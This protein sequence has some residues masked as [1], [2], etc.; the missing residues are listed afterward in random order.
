MVSL[1]DTPYLESGKMSQS[2][3]LTIWI[4]QLI[5]MKSSSIVSNLQVR[6]NYLFLIP[7][8]LLSFTLIMIKYYINRKAVLFPILNDGPW[9]DLNR[10]H[11][12]TLSP[13]L[14]SELSAIDN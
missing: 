1:R 8:T 3:V 6:L 12:D 2:Y 9:Q 11:L 7:A 4:S 13:A 5:I 14:P 10:G